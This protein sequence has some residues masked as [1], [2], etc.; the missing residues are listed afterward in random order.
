[1]KYAMN[2]IFKKYNNLNKKKKK[3]KKTS[4]KL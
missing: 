2:I 4:N 3:K 1:M